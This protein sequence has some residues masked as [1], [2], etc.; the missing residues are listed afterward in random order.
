MGVLSGAVPEEIVKDVV[1]NTMSDPTLLQGTFY[2]KFYLTRALVKVDMADEY[3]ASLGP[4]RDMVALGLT[5][6]AEKPEPTRSDSHAWSSTPNYEFL[7]T[8]C[9][10]RPNEPNFKSVLVKPA[11]GGLTEISGEMP[12]RLGS[13]KVDLKQNKKKVSGNVVLPAG[14]FGNFVW[15]NNTIPL[16]GGNNKIDMTK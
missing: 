2:Y 5:T 12:H 6:F 3:Y 13:I 1:R 4:W 7:A 8:I 14:L 11:F 9:G 15:G 10:I 16:H